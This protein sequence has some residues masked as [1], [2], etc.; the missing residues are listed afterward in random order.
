MTSP[1]RKTPSTS[2]N[3]P[4]PIVPTPP[5]RH[6][7]ACPYAPAPA[8]VSISS[9]T[10]L[11]RN[12]T[13]LL[14][15][16]SRR[17]LSPVSGRPGR[18]L[19]ATTSGGTGFGIRYPPSG[20]LDL[21]LR[22]VSVWIKDTDTFYFFVQVHA[23][24]GNNYYIR[25]EP[26]SGSPYPSGS[27]AIVPVGTQYRDGTWRELRRDL[28]ADLRAVFEVGVEYVRWF[29]IRGDYDLDELTLIGREERSYYYAGGQRVAMRRDGVV[30]YL[31][32]DHLGS[33]SLATDSGG[34]EVLDS[35]TLY[36]PYG[37]VRWP[38]GGSTLPTDYTFTGQRDE[39]GLGLM[40][41]HARFYDPYLGR[42]ISA[43]TIVP[44]PGNPQAL[45]RY[46]YVGN[47]PVKFRDPSGHVRC[48]DGECNLV[49]NPVTGE[50]T[51]RG[52]VRSL[53][54]G[55]YYYSDMYGYFDTYHLA[56]GS[57]ADIIAD[58]GQTIDTGGG[59]VNVEQRVSALGGRVWVQYIGTY[60]IS[61]DVN[62]QEALQIA[63]GI[64][65]DWGH[66]F[67]AWEGSAPG[68]GGTSFAIEDLPSHYVGFFGAATG[69]SREQVFTLLGNF[70][71]TNEEP[72]R[73]IKNHTYNPWVDDE[74]VPWPSIMIMTPIG[75][76]PH[77][78]RFVGGTCG[79]FLCNL[80]T[81][82]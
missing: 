51:W 30:Y 59:E 41:Y 44:E 27:Y 5:G 36:Y 1:T 42:F 58:V 9:R 54:G 72:T 64:Y 17:L 13:S 19:R 16:S 80:L 61:S 62:P 7:T 57:P 71:G 25:Y 3:V 82:P 70:K 68:G 31:H 79:G 8:S 52:P 18:V 60:Q 28:D 81:N 78:W 47:N 33:T 69:L 37:Q 4:A 46:S 53:P 32:T 24:D 55:R 6:P 43:D 49:D 63:L 34:G 12:A 11:V 38:T 23:T 50:L 14:S 65:M 56:T 48:V 67:E 29:C 35:R 2:L 40:D 22:D 39:A 74:S 75:S 26:S 45:N 73:D 21:P 66:R 15:S 10:W 76:G 77:T 20:S